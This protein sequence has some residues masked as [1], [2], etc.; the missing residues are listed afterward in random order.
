MVQNNNVVQTCLLKGQT[1]DDDGILKYT[2][3]I[4]K[5]ISHSKCYFRILVAA[6]AFLISHIKSTQIRSKISKYFLA[7]KR[8]VQKT[9]NN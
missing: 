2:Y 6:L 9:I 3:H 8:D 1:D 4:N 7:G 5:E